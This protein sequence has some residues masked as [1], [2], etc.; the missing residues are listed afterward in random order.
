MRNPIKI[1]QKLYSRIISVSLVIVGFVLFGVIGLM[2]I[3]GFNFLEAFW[4]VTNVV[5]T[6]GSSVRDY[7]HLSDPARIFIL[8]LMWVGIFLFLIAV[9]II[10]FDLMEG[11][12]QKA[13]N[14]YKMENNLNALDHH[15][16][17]CGFGRNGRQ[18]VR[19]LQNYHKKIVVIDKVKIEKYEGGE[20]DKVIFYQ[21]DATLD[22]TQKKCGITKAQA[23]ICAMPSDS[24][25]L[26]AVM[27]ARQLNPNITIITRASDSNSISKLKIAGANNV[28]MPDKIGGEHM[29]SMVVTPDLVEF[30]DQIN[31]EGSNHLNL[32][33]ISTDA[34]PKKYLNFPL[35][36]YL[37]NLD[38]PCIV[39]GYK[40]MDKNYVMNPDPNLIIN[41]EEF[42][43][44]FGRN[45]QII[46][47]KRKL[48]LK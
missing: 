44:F 46:D 41:P 20:F 7:A 14:T 27:T 22:S 34:I 6:V 29:A 39:I 23:I 48:N 1:I 26:Y 19:K 16:I 45:E 15:I 13:F 31:F 36:D 2:L 24:D 32:L 12:Y 10:A 43:I 9:S 30:L 35:K 40:D 4:T 21:G 18:A 47:L 38:S 42:I 3:E 25:N 28:I 37:K 11:K 17:I 5:T 8:F 33:E